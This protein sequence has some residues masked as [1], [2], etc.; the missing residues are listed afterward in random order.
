MQS[1]AK[2]FEVLDG[3]RIRCVLCPHFCILNDEEYGKCRV[4]WNNNG[5]LLTDVYGQARALHIDPIEKKPLYHFYPGS[6]ILS[7]GTPGC[8]LQCFFCQ[9]WDLSQT[10]IKTMQ[11]PLLPDEIL[12]LSMGDPANI[13]IAFTY[14]EPTIFYEYMYD[15]AVLFKEKGLKTCMISNGFINPKPLNDIIPIMD[16]FNI[17]LKAFSNTFYKEYTKSRLNPV[18]KSLKIIRAKNK[19]LELSFLV[20][21]GLNDDEEEFI[22]M[23]NWITDNLG[24]DTIFHLNRYFPN[25]NAKIPPTP[26]E[27]LED[28][29]ALAEE[30]L[31]YVYIGNFSGNIGHN[32]HC[33]NCGSIQ[34]SRIHYQTKS[35]LKSDGRCSECGHSIL[36]NFVTYKA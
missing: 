25:F 35:Y 17:D 29:F 7:L 18:L 1:P 6:R 12:N 30:K 27:K 3:E 15:T 20:I 22:E 34:I 23:L 8:N 31:D 2:Y 26:A 10:G 21:P 36:K 11:K 32:T 16:A 4:R 5:K 28:F 14:S 24:K 33:P 13:G 19:H 9:N